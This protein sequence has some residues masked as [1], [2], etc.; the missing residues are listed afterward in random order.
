MTNRQVLKFI[1]FGKKLF[2]LSVIQRK[3]IWRTQ[4]AREI[5]LNILPELLVNSKH[6][7]NYNHF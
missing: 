7:A 1:N 2:S 3:A 6:F 4:F 5:V